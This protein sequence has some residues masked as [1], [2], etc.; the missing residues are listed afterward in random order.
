VASWY[1]ARFHP[2]RKGR[3]AVQITAETVATFE[4]KLTK[5]D[6]E[7]LDSSEG[8]EPLVYV[9]GTGSILPG[10]ETQLEGKAAGDT[11]QV[12]LAPE[13]AYGEHDAGMVHEVERGQLPPDV[14]VTEGMQFHA[15]SEDGVHILTVLSV[16]GDTV[17]MDANH[18]LAGVALNFDVKVVE[19]RAATAEELEH[20]HVHGPGGHEH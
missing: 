1:G 3:T 4:Y 8:S 7:L 13:D 11:L 20:G 10:L 12:R 17:K 18:P 9:H 16:E 19:V 5:D 6:G 15:E 2:N 14:E